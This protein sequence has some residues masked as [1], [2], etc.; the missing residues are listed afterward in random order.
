M[1]FVTLA[2]SITPEGGIYKEQSATT[3]RA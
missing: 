1:P 3:L 2:R